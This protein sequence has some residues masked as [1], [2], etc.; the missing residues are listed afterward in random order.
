MFNVHANESNLT[1]PNDCPVSSQSL[2]L[3]QD[4][5]IASNQ[6]TALQGEIQYLTQP[7][8]DI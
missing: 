7:I 4:Q 1:M 3:V 6:N 8:R 5:N 2:Y